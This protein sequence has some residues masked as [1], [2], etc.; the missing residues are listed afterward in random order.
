MLTAEGCRAR[1]QRLIEQ[2]KPTHPLLLA[3]RINLRY[4]ANFYVEPMSLGA[5]FGGLLII[6]PDGKT[7]LYHDNR[8]PKTVDQAHVDERTPVTWYPGQ[9]PADGPRQLLLRPVV[10]TT[11]GRIHDSIGDAL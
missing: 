9:D 7:T 4:F 6:Q 2:L 8:L 1:R 5:D 11:G 10:E 3:D